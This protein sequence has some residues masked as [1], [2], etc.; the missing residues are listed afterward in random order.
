MPRDSRVYLEDMLAAAEKVGAYVSGMTRDDLEGDSKTLDAV[1]R[2]LEVIGEAAKNV[3]AD[4]REAHPEI[5][6]RKI[7]GL[8]DILIH[9]YFGVDLDVVWDIVQNKVPQLAEDLRRIL[10]QEDR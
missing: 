3:P 8:R 7:T 5:G 10:Q 1:V 4:V 6:W 2:N 9:H